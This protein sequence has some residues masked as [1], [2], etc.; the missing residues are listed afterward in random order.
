MTWRDKLEIGLKEN[1]AYSQRQ[2]AAKSSPWPGTANRAWPVAGDS[3]RTWRPDPTADRAQRSLGIEQ[4]SQDQSRTVRSSEAQSVIE[5]TLGGS[6]PA[7]R[8][9][10]VTGRIGRARRNEQRCR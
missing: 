5:G 7:W 4:A 9:G 6:W 2:F 1:A 8:C 10:I 3:A